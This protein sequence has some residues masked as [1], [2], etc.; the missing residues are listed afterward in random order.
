MFNLDREKKKSNREQS[1]VS[2]FEFNWKE[3]LFSTTRSFTLEQKR[4]WKTTKN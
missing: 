2:V 4:M 3:M 1:Q